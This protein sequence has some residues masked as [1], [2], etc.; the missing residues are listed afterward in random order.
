MIQMPKDKFIL[1]T[2]GVTWNKY[3][4]PAPIMGAVLSIAIVLLLFGTTIILYKHRRKRLQDEYAPDPFIDRGSNGGCSPHLFLTSCADSF[5]NS[6]TNHIRLSTVQ[7]RSDPPQQYLQLRPS[8]EPVQAHRD[9][10]PPPRP[11]PTVT[12]INYG[13]QVAETLSTTSLN[14][15]ESSVHE[16]RG[17]RLRIPGGSY[18]RPSDTTFYHVRLFILYEGSMS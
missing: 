16:P 9:F 11:P 2:G 5:S 13:D 3:V 12:S 18:P 6:M 17:Y 10:P 15:R 4:A 1:E 14:E 7:T 8:V